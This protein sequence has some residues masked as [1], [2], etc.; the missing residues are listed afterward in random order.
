[1]KT[2]LITGASD[3][4]GREAAAALRKQGWQVAVIGR[5]PARTQAVA[6]SLNAPHYIADFARLSEVRTLAQ[7]L[8][9][10]FPTIDVLVNN[11]GGMFSKQPLTEDGFEITFQVNHLAHFLLTH[12]LLPTLLKSRATVINTSSVAHR[13]IGLFF[14]LEDIPKPRR[15]SQ[16]LAYGNAKLCNILHTRE[17]HRR[18]SQQGIAAAA[19]HP[20]VVAS[21]FARE[22]TSFMRLLYHTSL[23]NLPGVITPQQGADTLLWLATTK[24][25]KDWQPG[26]YYASR[27]PAA[28]TRKA[29]DPQL[30]HDLWETSIRLCGDYL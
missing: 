21:S 30:A 9:A 28:M 24:P 5:N 14:N 29:R 16:H 25:G 1:M 20:G 17:L 15:Y 3:G 11:A 2:A 23:K 13:S 27:K 26:G 12:L 6:D 8:K 7:R 4:I 22:T 18:F 10:D 19:F